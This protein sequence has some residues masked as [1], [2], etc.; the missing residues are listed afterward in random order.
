MD[1]AQVMMLA[2]FIQFTEK[3]K[4]LKKPAICP[5]KSAFKFWFKK[6]IVSKK[7]GIFFFNAK[8][9]DLGC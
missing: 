4:N 8:C 1:T 7:V 5:G 9:F 3:K 2:T 6:G